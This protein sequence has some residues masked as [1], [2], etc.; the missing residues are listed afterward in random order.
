MEVKFIARTGIRLF[1]G[2]GFDRAPAVEQRAHLVLY[3]GVLAPSLV[4]PSETE[5]LLCA[6]RLGI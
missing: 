4:L 6:G 5:C 3:V 1:I 2:N